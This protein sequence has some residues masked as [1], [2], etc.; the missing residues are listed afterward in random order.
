MS[1]K[2]DRWE[3]NIL[4][5]GCTNLLGKSLFSK[6]FSAAVESDAARK[7]LITS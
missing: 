4:P 7:E 3:Q 5:W 2:K 1:L 6:D